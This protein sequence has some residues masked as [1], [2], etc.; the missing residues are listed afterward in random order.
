MKA[1]DG[2][3]PPKDAE[4]HAYALGTAISTDEDDLANAVLI[5][6]AVSLGPLDFV[7]RSCMSPVDARQAAAALMD[8][9]DRVEAREHVPG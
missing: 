1:P 4:L 6:Q 5:R 8:L 2:Y 3:Q 7:V 9:A